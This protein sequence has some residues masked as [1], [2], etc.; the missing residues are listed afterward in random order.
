M[1]RAS[2]T[3]SAMLVA[4]AALVAVF[5]LPTVAAAPHGTTPGWPATSREVAEY[6][7]VARAGM[8]GLSSI[9]VTPT[10]TTLTVGENVTFSAVPT[11]TGG[12]CP[13]G[14]AF[15]WSLNGDL[16]TLGY[17]PTANRVI[18]SLT[19][20]LEVPTGIAFDPSNGDL[21]VTNDNAYDETA[22][23]TLT[24]ISGSTNSVVGSIPVGASPSGIAYDPENG[25]LYVAN[26]GSGFVSVI[27]A[28]THVTVN[29]IPVPLVGCTIGY[30]WYMNF[31]PVAYDGADGTILVSNYGSG[32]LSVINTTTESLSATI[33][34]GGEPYGLAYD[35]ANRYVYATEFT[36]PLVDVLN[37]S[38]DLLLTRVPV[39]ELPSGIAYDS[40]N[41]DL[42]VADASLYVPNPAG[43]GNVSV[44][45]GKTDTL[46]DTIPTQGY[47]WTVA[48]DSGNGDLYE[49]DS[50][51]TVMKV[52]SGGTDKVI[53]SVPIGPALQGTSTDFA[54][55]Y[56]DENG[57]VYV[58][59]INANVVSV[60]G[61]ADDNATLTAGG[62]TGSTFLFV[63][64]TWNGTTVAAGPIEITVTPSAV[65]V[66]SGFTA[67]PKSVV[68]ENG[69]YLNVT[70]VG[71]TGSLSY[72]Y[73]GL[74]LGCSSANVPSL[75][76]A[77]GK[78]GTY[79][80][81]V[82]VNDT[83]G[84][85]TSA[86]VRFAVTPSTSSGL[87][88]SAFSASP[89]T[90]LSGQ[91]SF[92]NVT[93]S[94]GFAPLDYTY[95]GLPSGCTSIDNDSLPCRPAGDGNYTVRVFVN[96]TAGD[97]VTSTVLLQVYPTSSE[98]L[99][100][101][102]FVASPPDL[103][104]GGMT[105]ML[106]SSDGG[107]GAVTFAY[108]GLPSGC[109]SANTASLPCTPSDVGSFSIRAYAND[110]V[111]KSA[112]ALAT[113][114]VSAPSQVALTGVSVEPS[115]GSVQ[116]GTN[117]SLTLTA[118]PVCSGTP[119]CPLSVTYTWSLNVSLG[120]LN[121]NFG[122]TVVFTPGAA[123]GEV[124]VVVRATLNGV[125]RSGEAA[126]TV[127]P[128]APTNTNPTPPVTSG[129]SYDS[130]YLLFDVVLGIV[131][132]AEVALFIR[133]PEKPKGSRD[134]AQE[135]E[136]A[137]EGDGASIERSTSELD[138]DP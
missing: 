107:I 95:T 23:S 60:I 5:L 98:G 42:Y 83:V 121:P 44:I 27:N 74:P 56:D 94:G 120:S 84:D 55:L 134:G 4:S 30:K 54:D 28:S 99:Q 129:T 76:C 66:I 135:E 39:T 17:S 32:S 41:Q 45:D 9:S 132:M 18:A 21:Y 122:S 46:V 100:I 43:D 71:G 6:G 51:T 77:P 8:V 25:N 47:P 118:S 109:V 96:D 103:L 79:T 91:T 75:R 24:V 73:S 138:P 3:T 108:A 58:T 61:G 117:Q 69:V 82:F 50:N 49:T 112:N 90:V 26:C 115:Q 81:R 1:K 10:F 137:R 127:T 22:N 35:P 80:P 123:P 92:L 88:I 64:A 78:V 29:E 110:S 87:S 33:N 72:S 102:S 63:N 67:T 130:D 124:L 126:V 105:T 116:A 65:P 128:A 38:T 97:S 52:I 59:G 136:P 119:K 11:C 48:Y 13:A 62:A 7:P 131:L 16:G 53:G 2:R 20:E 57:L 19:S 85:S 31:A 36:K 93:A 70:A 111:G 86:E 133:G 104:I 106:V 89:A 34:L 12:P 14:I 114:Q 101:T 125:S 113:L 15:N 40:A 37:G 68:V